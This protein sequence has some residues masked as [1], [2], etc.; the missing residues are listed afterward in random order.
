MN[1]LTAME[2]M[3]KNQTDVSGNLYC[4]FTLSRHDQP[5]PGLANVFS[6]SNGQTYLPGIKLFRHQIP[7]SFILRIL[8]KE[9]SKIDDFRNRNPFFYWFF[10][11][12]HG[13]DILFPNQLFFLASTIWRQIRKSLTLTILRLKVAEWKGETANTAG[14]I[15]PYPLFESIITDFIEDNW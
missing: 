15:D 8:I 3:K 4:H 12:C 11:F 10:H 9:Q 13:P 6:C 1:V 5:P 14:E 2:V 7:P